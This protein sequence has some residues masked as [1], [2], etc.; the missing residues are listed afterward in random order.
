MRSSPT[1]RGPRLWPLYLG[2]ALGP[3]GGAMINVILPELAADLDASVTE[4][5]FAV[6]TYL[7]PFSL[8]LLISGTLGQRWGLARTARVAFI[9]Y[10]VGTLICIM[11]GTITP[12]LIGRAIQGVANAFTSPLLIALILAHTGVGR[13][14]RALGIY[15]SIQASG[16]AIAPL[17]GGVAVGIDFRL[18]FA[19][20]AMF[21]LVIAALVTMRDEAA[22]AQGKQISFASLL[23][24]RLAIACLIA[25][26]LQF[27][28]SSVVVFTG[29]VAADRFAMAAPTR[30]IVVAGFG[31]AGL[32]AGQVIGAV[33]DRFG[34][35]WIGPPLLLIGAGSAAVC[36][37]TPTITLLVV[38][39][40]IG[41]LASAGGRILFTTLALASTPSNPA[42]ATSVAMAS[43]FI[44]TASVPLFIPLYAASAPTLAWIIVAS[45]VVGAVLAIIG[46]RTPALRSETTV[47]EIAC[48][49]SDQTSPT[50]SPNT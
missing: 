29:L 2:G 49:K 12:F 10:A 50:C 22:D 17:A 31:I 18:A 20:S 33:M 35:T 8:V 16:Y 15:A 5:G 42:G 43:Q 48:R 34:M 3:F 26:C 41:G 7:L 39:V 28:A 23:S 11:A 21:A 25:L 19:V 36:V 24:G 37:I 14:G 13:Q 38:A 4:A 27:A 30:G 9:A 44:G 1:V 40:W 45:G 6:S 32:L 47:K 46:T